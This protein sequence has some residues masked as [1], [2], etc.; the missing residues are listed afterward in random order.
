MSSLTRRDFINASIGLATASLV[1]GAPEPGKEYRACVIGHTGRGAYGHGLDMS[2]QKV[3][4]V[5]V[6][7]VADRDEQSGAEATRRIGA[8]RS[9]A[10]YREMLVKE[11]PNLVAICPYFPEQR[12]EM[13]RAAAEV[14]A[15]IYIEKP[16][17]TS[18]QDADAMTA[19]V[20][21]NNVR[22]AVAHHARLAPVILHLKKLLD[23]GLIGELLEIRSRGKE[24][25]RAG[26]EDL[27]ILGVHCLYLMRYFAG[28][29]SSCSARVTQNGKEVTINDRRAGTIPLG[30]IAGDSIHA[31]YAFA[32]G[33]QGHFASQ[34]GHGGRS[35]DFQVVLYGAKG[36]VQIHIGNEPRIYYLPDPL[37][38]PG[39]SG[40]SWEPVPGAP[41]S[42]D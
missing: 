38:S 35:S 34:K 6:V 1:R 3:R 17:A 21:K 37:W 25:S 15:H 29:P 5:T 20:E 10:D 23:D 9:Y 42:T 7:A 4:N 36:V 24:D 40:V 28:E 31:T 41:A 8:A 11:R 27:M 19:A 22:T 39:K 2:F 32:N 13:T 12:V 16:I 33:V 18:L 30:P 14:G 26:G